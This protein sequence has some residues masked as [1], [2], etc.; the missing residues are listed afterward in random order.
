MAK[1]C[2]CCGQPIPEFE[3]IVADEDREEVR[4]DGKSVHLTRQQFRLFDFLLSKGG[5]VAR[6]DAIY[7][8]L[9]DHLPECDQPEPKIIDVLICKI[10]AAIKPLGIEI[11]TIWGNGYSLKVKNG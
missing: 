10:R 11:E 3:G 6:S 7:Q 1:I 4:Y 9:F 5:R 8:V 2:A